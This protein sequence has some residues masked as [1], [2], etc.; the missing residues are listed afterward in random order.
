MSYG[1]RAGATI[2]SHSVNIEA[3]GDSD[4]TIRRDAINWLASASSAETVHELLS[5]LRHH[6]RDLSRLNAVIQV[7]TR[8]PADVVPELTRLLAHPDHEVRMYAALALGERGDIRAIE[9]LLATLADGDTNVRVHAIEALGKLRAGA[10]VDALLEFVE[11]RDFELA[12]PALDALIVIGD[13]R[14]VHKL[15][16]L[17]QDSVYK[18]AAIEAFGELGDRSVVGPLME[19]LAD[20]HVPPQNV[21]AALVRLHI[22]YLDR[23]DDERTIPL[24]VR[25]VA[26]STHVQ[27]LIAT[28]NRSSPVD[29]GDTAAVLSWL[30]GPQV[31]QAL[32][33]WID[34]APPCQALI[35]A[36]A[37]RG[38]AIVP[39]LIQ[40]IPLLSAEGR[41]AAIAVLA[42]IADRSAVPA[43]LHLLTEE[44]NAEIVRQILEALTAIG[45]SA[46][47]SAARSLLGH[48]DPQVRQAAVA[49]VNCFGHPE[50][51]SH[52]LHDLQD[53]SPWVRESALKVA[54]YH[55]LPECFE[56]ILSC[57]R[58][59]HER[60]RRSAVEHLPSFHDARVLDR[61][62]QALEGDTPAVR[63]SAAI[64]LSRIDDTNAERVLT[65]ALTDED[66][67]VRYFAIRSLVAIDKLSGVI[68]TIIYLAKTDSA[69]QVR[70]AAV[71]ALA[72]GGAEAFS[73]LAELS[74]SEYADLSHAALESL[75]TN[76]HSGA[77]QLLQSA[78]GSDDSERRVRAIGALVLRPDA[79]IIKTLLGHVKSSD[80]RTSAAALGALAAL[81]FAEAA[82]ALVEVAGIPGKRDPC[83][84]ALAS[85]RRQAVAALNDHLRHGDL[86]TR[87]IAVEVLTRIRVPEAVAILESAL[88][89]PAA[90]VRFAALSSLSHIR[91]A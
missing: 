54:A 37:R 91:H 4:W 46:A 24:A 80:E 69:M 39:V 70:V 84:R 85:M 42:C 67:W 45:D 36:C 52:L 35:D 28:A 43:M 48:D 34:Q 76:E 50:I 17:L 30:E 72:R 26:N 6:H 7:L 40:R 12:F 22:R 61:L 15:N 19:M 18:L 16:P 57:C 51:R 32:A 88:D 8:T 71:E 63:S 2:A 66:V 68:P 78:L 25:E 55:R 77:R 49:A 11:R 89:D 5:V 73:V 44:D 20:P 65:K 33:E 86:E 79:S 62:E 21:V 47:Y 38:V 87:R 81:L 10:A 9:S 64:A 56:L 3:L 1:E 75:G 74:K 27:L 83:I 59:S 41:K 58:D 29:K 31:D 23:F 14:I 60:V 90:A 82:S 13:G 53:S